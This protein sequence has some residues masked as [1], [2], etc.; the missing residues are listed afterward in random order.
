MSM[1][2]LLLHCILPLMIGVMFYTLSHGSRL[3][4]F[5]WLKINRYIEVLLQKISLKYIY[6]LNS[7]KYINSYFPDVLW[8]YAFTS[9]LILYF[10]E[11]QSKYKFEIILPLIVGIITEVLQYYNH[12]NGT[13][14]IFDLFAYFLGSFISFLSIK[15]SVIKK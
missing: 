9:T 14:D 5:S 2:K 7:F 8:S 6:N 11:S 12:I 13:F 3:V 10:S 15:R 4:L 1:R